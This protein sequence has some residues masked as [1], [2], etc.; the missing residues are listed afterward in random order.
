MFGRLRPDFLSICNPT[1][2]K[3]CRGD[4]NAVADARKSFPSGHASTAFGAATVVGLF[5][6]T[7]AFTYHAAFHE[8]HEFSSLLRLMAKA[9]SAI[10]LFGA[11]Y[12]AATRLADNRHHGGDV[13]ASFLIGIV[14]GCLSFQACFPDCTLQ[15]WA[16]I[17][18][19]HTADSVQGKHALPEAIR[20]QDRRSDVVRIHSVPS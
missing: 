19:L 11:S 13:I 10:P 7:R 16:R 8:H 1:L 3:V 15:S 17:L 14:F 5:A 9:L 2:D 4:R 6:Y 18:P 20:L 12:I